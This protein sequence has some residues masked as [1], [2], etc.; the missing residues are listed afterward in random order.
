MNPTFKITPKYLSQ[1]LRRKKVDPIFVT[2]D[3]KCLRYIQKLNGTCLYC[4]EQIEARKFSFSYCYQCEVW[5]LYSE[6]TFENHSLELGRAIQ[7]SGANKV[8][9]VP[10]SITNLVGGSIE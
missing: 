9:L 6:N 8:L 1:L 7:R 3:P 5:V 2:S 4:D 10:F